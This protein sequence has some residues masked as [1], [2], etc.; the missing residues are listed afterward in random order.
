MLYT[1]LRKV[2]KPI[3]FTRLSSALS[4]A[5]EIVKLAFVSTGRIAVLSDQPAKD[6]NV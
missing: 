1:K 5:M 2:G 3:F 4:S 6:W